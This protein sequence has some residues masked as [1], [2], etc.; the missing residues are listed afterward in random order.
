M[1]FF[2]FISFSIFF[3]HPPF[4]HL[5]FRLFSFL[6]I[7]PVTSICSLFFLFLLFFPFS[8]PFYLIL[9]YFL[10]FPFFSILPLP[11]LPSHL[12][13]SFFTS[14]S[15]SSSSLFHPITLLLLFL[16]MQ[17]PMSVHLHFFLS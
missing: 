16:Y 6:S 15:H 1:I 10:S 2:F 17:F 12:L 5:L 11:P 7:L 13:A 3:P 4:H 9:L 8:P 14:L